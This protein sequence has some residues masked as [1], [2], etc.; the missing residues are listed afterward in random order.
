MTS[1]DNAR[2]PSLTW[3]AKAALAGAAALTL[4][5]VAGALSGRPPRFEL[6]G[7]ASPAIQIHLAGVVLALAVG[8]V[9][10]AG[11]KGTRLHRT[12]GW[13]WAAAMMLA[14][15][16]S[17]F[18]RTINDGAFS[19]IHI[20]SV[21]TLIT[22]PA[23]LLAAHRHKVRSHAAAMTSIYLGGMVVAG[24][25]AFLPGRLMWEVFFG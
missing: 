17:F 7:E 14:A 9:Q 4:A 24:G 8:A 25:F 1:I 5:A 3:G 19:P 18:V 20:L 12:L 2:A 13:S 6:I 11:P 22:L 10:L 16:S 23:A 21:L 15:I